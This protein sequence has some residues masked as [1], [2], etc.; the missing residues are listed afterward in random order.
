[1]RAAHRDADR[2]LQLR[3]S[4]APH[5]L[6]RFAD[7][8]RPPA[9]TACSRSTCRSKRPRSSA[10]CSASHGLD[11]I[12]LL[13]PTTTAERISAAAA[14]GSGFL[15]GISRLGRDGRA[16][17]GVASDAAAMVARDPRRDH[18]LPLA[19]GFGI[20][21]PEHVPEI[22]RFADAAVVG[23]ALVSVDRRGTAQADDA[24]AGGR[25]IRAMAEGHDASR[26]RRDGERARGEDDRRAAP[27]HRRAG[28][29]A[30]AAAQRA[31][32]VRAV[33]RRDQARAGH[34][35]YQP[36]RETEV[37]R[38]V[39]RARST[40]GGPLG[41]AALARLFERIIDE[42]RRA[43][44]RIGAVATTKRRG[45]RDRRAER[46]RCKPRG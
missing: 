20:S 28:R 42:A 6:R 13:S 1:M 37:L 27:A 35:V 9:S 25:G 5:G 22:G 2:A 41:P 46:P 38:H 30:R 23:S 32:R 17:H 4:A 10:T 44:A 8:P 33:D 19:L 45:R 26:S 3:Q 11:T 16:R 12:F 7:G 15:Y 40:M 18:D 43:R 14:L 31:G 24:G 36:E 34:R 39:R 29:T 21:R